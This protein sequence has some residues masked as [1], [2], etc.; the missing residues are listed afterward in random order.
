[1]IYSIVEG[2]FTKLFG[3]CQVMAMNDY[4]NL[5]QIKCNI[6]GIDPKTIYKGLQKLRKHYSGKYAVRVLIV[7]PGML[8]VIIGAPKEVS[9]IGNNSNDFI[10]QV[11]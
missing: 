11:C 7:Y 6:E 10:I 2:L 1:M 4:G 3:N 5:I 9:G 8:Q